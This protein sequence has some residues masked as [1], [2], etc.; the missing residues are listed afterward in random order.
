MASVQERPRCARC[1][2]ALASLSVEAG[3]QGVLGC[4]ACGGEFC[5]R[6]ALES[7][8]Q[9]ARL[10]GLGNA[11]ARP[12]LDMAAPLRYVRCPVCGQL[13]VRRNYGGSSGVVVDVCGPHG[14]WFDRGELSQVL[15]F[16]ASGGLARAEADAASRA[17]A[18]RFAGAAG[19]PAQR[20]DGEDVGDV[21]V[22]CIEIIASII[23]D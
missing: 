21:A 2:I 3:S 9:K 22:A 16:C 10:A 7:A 14:V 18:Q 17:A 4:P 15:A 8:V 23:F 19:T 13:M 5:E 6:A 1:D 11:Y 20:S 12:V